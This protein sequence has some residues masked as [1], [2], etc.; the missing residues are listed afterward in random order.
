M[1]Q[2]LLSFLIVFN[3]YFAYA[4]N[5]K[6]NVFGVDVCGGFEEMPGFLK[7]IDTINARTS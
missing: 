3:S 6:Y 1:K 2:L 4:Q 5:D 7:A